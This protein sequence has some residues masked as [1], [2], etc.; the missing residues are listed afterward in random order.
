MAKAKLDAPVDT[1]TQAT[2]STE[3]Q[4]TATQETSA[5]AL[6]ESVT[7]AAP[8]GYIHEDGSLRYWLAGVEVKIKEE[9]E[10]LMARLAPLV[11]ID[12]GNKE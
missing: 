7:L 5:K 10:D 11:G 9:I 6:P 3:T 1:E 12:H 4:A 8:F 2:E